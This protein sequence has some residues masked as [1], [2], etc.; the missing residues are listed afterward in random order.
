MNYYTITMQ[1][2]E[3]EKNRQAALITA[4]ITGAM[5]LCFILLKWPLPSIEIPP[6]EAYIEIELDQPADFRAGGGGGGGN[7]VQAS[8]EKGTA[9]AP[10]VPGTLAETKDFETDENDETNP[11]VNK[12]INPKRDIKTVNTNTAVADTK[13]KPV[14]TPAPPKPKAVLGRTTT[15]SG[16]GGGTAENYD[17]SGGSGTGYGVGDGNGSG[18]GTG[19]GIGG[20]NGTGT[21]TGTGPRKVSGNRVVINPKSMN[22]GENLR[23]K[24]LAEILVSPD[25][26]GTFVRAVRGSTYTGGEAVS[27]IREWL[28]RNRFNKI[29]QSSTVVYEFNFLLGG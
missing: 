7:P 12:P 28:R 18:G 16:T 6:Q 23:G 27:I 14:E 22:A 20:G 2:F 29:P 26:I 15:G 24:V 4:G 3:K 11:A 17:R 21:G 8:G 10:P 9:Y 13:P 5:I 1:A 19:G 25:G